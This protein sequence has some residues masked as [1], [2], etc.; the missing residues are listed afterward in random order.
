MLFNKPYEAFRRPYTEGGVST[1][2]SVRLA[3]GFASRMSSSI[4]PTKVVYAA[5]GAL[6]LSCSPERYARLWCDLTP[7]FF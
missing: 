4:A 7:P 2:S 1:G 5:D 3:S 6:S